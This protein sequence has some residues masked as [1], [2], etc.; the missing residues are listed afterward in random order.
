MDLK[1][2][3]ASLSLAIVLTSCA[4]DDDSLPGDPPGPAVHSFSPAQGMMT[5]VITIEGN[6]FS[7]VVLDNIVQ[8]NNAPATVQS[9]SVEKLVV[10]VPDSARTG[11]I[12]VTVGGK[13]TTSQQEF[14][15]LSPSVESISDTLTSPGRSLQIKGQ[16]FL[17]S[18]DLMRVYVGTAPAEITAAE[19]T[20]LTV[21]IPDVSGAN[22]VTV[23]VGT[24]K[25]SSEKTIEVCNGHPELVISDINISS[26]TA[27]D[28]TFSCKLTNI[29]NA[30]LDLSRMIMQNYASADKM[31][32]AGDAAA[33]GLILDA[34]GVLEQ[35]EFHVVEWTSNVD[36]DIHQYLIITVFEKEGQVVGECRIDNNEVAKL[37]E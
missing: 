8:F 6:N 5:D 21:I 37:I 35:D 28:V 18:T 11:K 33:G 20:S 12:K 30:A 10:V 15:I 16:R 25:A 34:G 36:H 13:A 29:G 3:L 1:T 7:P 26:I 32:N 17:P 22:N 23:Q 24:Q 31:K 2:I 9:A 27:T 4:S 14:T 19:A